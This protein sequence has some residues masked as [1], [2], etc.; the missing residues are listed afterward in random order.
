MEGEEEPGVGAEGEEHVVGGE[1]EVLAEAQ[2][3]QKDCHSQTGK[4]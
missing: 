3:D 4:E 1:G 2:V